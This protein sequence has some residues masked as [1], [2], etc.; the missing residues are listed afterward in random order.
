MSTIRRYPRAALIIVAGVFLACADGP[1]Q[2]SQPAAAE[3]SAT[4][5]WD[6][7]ASTTWNRRVAGLLALRPP[8]NGQAAT[9]RSSSSRR[10]ASPPQS[11]TSSATPF[12]G[13]ASRTATTS[14]SNCAQLAGVS[15]RDTGARLVS[16]AC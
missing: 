3:L 4:K 12:Y 13:G 10:A 9:S 7:T 11:S 2:P 5:F 14:G 16:S 1:T 15:G 8:A 6:V